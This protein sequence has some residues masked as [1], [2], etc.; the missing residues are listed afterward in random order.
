MFN[1]VPLGS[2]ISSEALLRLRIFLHI[3]IY[4][5]NHSPTSDMIRP[6]KQV[7][8]WFLNLGQLKGLVQKSTLYL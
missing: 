7:C 3:Y 8:F 5:Y 6:K 2:F 1:I 4:I